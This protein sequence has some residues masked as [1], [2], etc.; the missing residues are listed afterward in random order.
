MIRVKGTQALEEV[1]QA[2]FTLYPEPCGS[3][4]TYTHQTVSESKRQAFC[5]GRENK[6]GEKKKR[7]W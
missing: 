6:A 2:L 3:V 1:W 4:H 7:G 5:K